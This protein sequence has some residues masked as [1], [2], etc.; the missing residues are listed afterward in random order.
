VQPT[1]NDL[2]MLSQALGADL[3]VYF[4]DARTANA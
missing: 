1:A 4:P 3:S 2:S